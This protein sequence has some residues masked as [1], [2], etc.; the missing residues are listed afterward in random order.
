MQ[1]LD[2]NPIRDFIERARSRGLKGLSLHVRVGDAEELVDE[3]ALDPTTAETVWRDAQANAGGFAEPFTAFVLHTHREDG[4]EGPSRSFSV[5]R[6]M[7]PAHTPDRFDPGDKAALRLM[8]EQVDRSHKV[9]AGLVPATMVQ[10]SQMIAGLSGP[11]EQM[12]NTQAEAIRELREQRAATA[13]AER[14]MLKDAARE[15]RL[16]RLLDIGINLAPVVIAKLAAG[17]EKPSEGGG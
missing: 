16:D 13:E 10:L 7:L 3:Y 5:L 1:V 17:D 15:Q 6:T 8:M 11:I 2:E 9:I 12:A 14:T 4:G